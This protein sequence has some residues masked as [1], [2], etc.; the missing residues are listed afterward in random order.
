M[1]IL[2]LLILVAACTT[3]LKVPEPVIDEKPPVPATEP[4]QPKQ[5]PVPKTKIIVVPGPK[6][7]PGCAPPAQ[8]DKQRLLQDLDCL[9]QIE[10]AK[11]K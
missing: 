10:K 5:Q 4:E 2:V 9:I 3:A 8:T 1:R 6:V 7:I 11:P